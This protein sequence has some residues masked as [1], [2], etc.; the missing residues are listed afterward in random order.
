MTPERSK[1]VRLTILRKGYASSQYLFHQ[2]YIESMLVGTNG[3]KN[4]KCKK[5]ESK[6]TKLQRGNLGLIQERLKKINQCFLRL[7]MLGSQI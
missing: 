5:K 3:L 7:F 6:S 2:E 4:C 1:M